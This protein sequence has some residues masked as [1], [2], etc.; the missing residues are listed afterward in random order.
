[1]HRWWPL[2]IAVVLGLTV[3]PA[4]AHLMVAQ[5]GTL[6]FSGSGGFLVLSVPTSSLQNID[7]N[8]D[9]LLS[10]AEL[11][12]HF[13]TIKQQITD[14]LL[15]SDN[16]EPLQ[17]EGLMLNLSPKDG[18]EGHPADQLI[19][20]G[21]YALHDGLDNLSFRVA[22]WGGDS[23]QQSLSLTVTKDLKDPQ[24]LMLT[25][26]NPEVNLFETRF[27]LLRSYVNIGIRH[28]VSGLDH[29]LFLIVVI[30]AALSWKKLLT[31]LGVFTVGHAVSMT[32][33]VFCNFT[34][35]SSVVEP[36]IAVT[37][38]AQAA[39][40]V[41]ARRY[42]KQSTSLRFAMVFGCSLIHGL[43]LGGALTMLGLRPDH[44]GATLL[45]FNLGVELGQVAIAVSALLLLGLLTRRFGPAQ[46]RFGTALLQLCA[47][48]IGLA[49]LIQRLF[50]A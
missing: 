5:K 19:V 30:A 42:T 13:S 3:T 11:S 34:V 41:W 46:V 24:L 38:I 35:P 39:Y 31:V 14:G 50:F 21:R 48:A 17:F 12:T 25:P 29:V 10:P 36:A 28:V 22:L 16:H 32:A 7:D 15:L 37:V 1:M 27:Q 26:S 18:E 40:D 33:V 20:M 44:Q 43:G 4:H 49:W 45:G 23:S 2:L 8:N 6:N 9:H 47:I